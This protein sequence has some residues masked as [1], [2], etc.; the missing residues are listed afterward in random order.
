MNQ[1]LSDWKG[2]LDGKGVGCG[3][4]TGWHALAQ[5]AVSNADFERGVACRNDHE[6]HR[7]V[8]KVGGRQVD[9]VAALQAKQAAA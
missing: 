2:L 4:R 6:V 9:A 7:R 5:N 3:L 1:R 8:E